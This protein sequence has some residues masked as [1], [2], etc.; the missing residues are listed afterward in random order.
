MMNWYNVN[1][2][3]EL[4]SIGKLT[5]VRKIIKEQLGENIKVSGRS[6]QN[7]YDN[8]IEFRSVINSLDTSIPEKPKKNSESYFT[9]QS[10][11]Y[12]FYLTE[13]DG[14]IRMK[15]LGVTQKLFTNEK[16]AKNWR[17]KISKQIHP[18]ICHHPKSEDAMSRLNQMYASMV[19]KD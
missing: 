15:K 4:K 19:G 17:D 11:E 16:S 5:Q 13:L 6:W 12:I 8:I 1:S 2:L 3:E 10:N 9:S 14:Q 18:D 7:L